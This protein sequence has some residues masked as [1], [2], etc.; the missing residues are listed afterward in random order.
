MSIRF[1]TLFLLLFLN[2]KS[3]SQSLPSCRIL[4]LPESCF[5]NSVI[6]YEKV[7]KELKDYNIWSNILAVAFLEKRGNSVFQGAHAV[8][9]I[10]W[11]NRLYVYD[12]NKGTL[13]MDSGVYKINYKSDAK[14]LATILF[15][16]KRII[17]CDFLKD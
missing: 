4:N 15:P 14:A 1:L 17:D 5:I 12:V 11:Q 2:F 6:A 16:D 10:E 7:N 8:C 9:V 3:Y 13:P